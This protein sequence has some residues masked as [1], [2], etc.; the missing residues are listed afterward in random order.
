MWIS[1]FIIFD[2]IW[3]SRICRFLFFINLYTI[4]SRNM[5][6]VQYKKINKCVTLLEQH[7]HTHTPH[8]FTCSGL[9]TGLQSV[10]SLLRALAWGLCCLPTCH[11]RLSQRAGVVLTAHQRP[12]Q[13]KNL[14]PPCGRVWSGCWGLVRAPWPHPS[15]PSAHRS[16]DPAAASLFRRCGRCFT[17]QYDASSMCRTQWLDTCI[18]YGLIATISLVTTCQRY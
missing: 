6:V 12:Q 8:I 2:F 4:Y 14:S 11:C 3:A 9:H 7:R 1:E 10:L 13:G 5:E 18:H 15:D 16:G 17:E